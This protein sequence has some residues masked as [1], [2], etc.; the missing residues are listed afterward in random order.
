MKIILDGRKVGNGSD[1]WY[2]ENKACF[3]KRGLNKRTVL[4]EVFHHLVYCNGLEMLERTE[5]REAND[6]V[7]AFLKNVR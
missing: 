1:A 6:Y 4:H 5:E 7:R 2:F 3:K